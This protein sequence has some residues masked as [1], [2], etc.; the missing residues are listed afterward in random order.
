[1]EVRGKTVLVSAAAGSGKT[2]T[3]TERI[4]RKLMD[5]ENPADIS[6]MLI[7]T[8]TKAAASDL[9]LKISR[10][11]NRALSENPENRYLYSQMMKLGSA[12]ICTIDSFYYKVVKNHFDR[13]G[14]P[15]GIS[16]IDASEANIMRKR[17]LAEIID[18]FYE[19]KGEPF[20]K[21]MDSFM[22]TRGMIDDG[23]TDEVLHAYDSMLSYP[24][25]I[26]IIKQNELLLHEESKRPFFESRVGMNIKKRT[27]EALSRA[28]KS[29]NEMLSAMSGCPEIENAFGPAVAYDKEHFKRTREAVESGDYD[30]TVHAFSSFSPLPASKRPAGYQRFSKTRKRLADEYKGLASKY[31]NSNEAVYQREFARTAVFVSVLYDIISEL[32]RRFSA[33]KLDRG[34]C[35]FTDNKRFAMKLFIGADGAPT[36]LASLYAEKYDEIYIDE[37]QDTDAVQD[38]IFSAISKPGNRFMVGDIKQSIYCFRGANSSV[39]SR[40]KASFPLYGEDEGS[41]TCSIYMSENFRCDEPI[42]D[43][44]NLICGHIFSRGPNN[45]GYTED[46]KLRFAKKCACEER[47]SPKVR[48]DMIKTYSSS[49][50]A[51]MDEKNAAEHSGTGSEAEIRNLVS[52]IKRLLTSEDVLCEDGGKL[53]RI[54]P[55]DIAV[56]VRNNVKIK[57]VSDALSA[58]GIPCTVKKKINFFENPEIILALS[59]L[60]AIDNPRRDVYL[61]GVLRSALF[62]FSM[63]EL[64]LIR[65]SGGDGASLYDD[66]I[67]ASENSGNASLREKT[68]AFI[69]KLELY[70]SRASLLPVDK[71][72]RFIY[73]ETAMLSL[74]AKNDET[75][76]GDAVKR[77]NL[78]MLYDYARRFEGGAYK[79]LYSFLSYIDDLCEAGED[80]TPPSAGDTS[81]LVRIMT[82]HASKGLEFPV[83]II[84]FTKEPFSSKWK[85]AV[86]HF[87]EELGFSAL[88]RDSTGMASFDTVLRRAVIEKS[89]RA[90]RE[91]EMRLLY[92]AMTRA[93][94]QLYMSASAG[95]LDWQK[96]IEDS[97]VGADEYSI[98][99]GGNYFA[100]IASAIS[101]NGEEIRRSMD[102]FNPDISDLPRLS[103]LNREKEAENDD[104]GTALDKTEILA[105]FTERFSFEYPYSY[106]S[107]LPAKL[108]V[109][110]LYPEVLDEGEAEAS[111]AEISLREMPAFLMPDA[112]KASAA[113]K[114][115]ATHTFMQFC[116]FDNVKKCGADEEIAR[117]CSVG[118]LDPEMAG[119]INVRHIEKFFK[120]NFWREVE[121]ALKSGGKIYR[122][123]RFNIKL[124]ASRFTADESFKDRLSGESIVVQGVI[125]LLVVKPEGDII[126]CDYKTDYITPE[127]MSDVSLLRDKM[128]SAH[129][130]QL[131]YYKTAVKKIFGALPKR[132][133]IYSLP[134][135]EAIDLDIKECEE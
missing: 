68:A 23:I 42:I 33:E 74:I 7:V 39:F 69:E 80:I 132:T 89:E 44:T 81:N 46:D 83:C 57:R 64:L 106:L 110:K 134:F 13:L 45:I 87:D 49:A 54:E 37:Y 62:G 16:I 41:D 35:D 82:M 127:E 75:C 10:E 122:E 5:K 2:A 128:M 88:L 26:D 73:S 15:S 109:S 43:T 124:P 126:L 91:E 120:S 130:S 31:F 90:S 52:H 70:R 28:E 9:R 32:E 20:K 3:L 51:K 111:S 63:E 112:E 116:D 21:F 18:E 99:S 47:I 27:L 40:S 48:F 14:L 12:D 24:A 114:G 123:Q 135:G 125:D 61:A 65:K 71:F 131:S 115:T 72:I 29:C 79:G 11:L 93:R 94:E 55:R 77:A 19:T 59:L 67:F 76:E 36:E 103:P 78:L 108:S 84:P 101:E 85:N 97:A 95:S 129:A 53:R 4:I 117:M 86:I 6:R 60:R 56:L 1:M 25:G 34:L 118:L 96:D 98:M 133:V 102:L 105:R 50:L 119:L 22:T 30:K 58:C 107:R 8:Y 113:E 38:A 100:W 92:V 17:I 121:E 104:S 66:L